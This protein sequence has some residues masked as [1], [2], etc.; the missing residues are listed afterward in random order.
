MTNVPGVFA[1]GDGQHGPRTAVEAIRSGKIA[2][3]SIDAWLLGKPMDPSAGK[4]VHR[5]DVVPLTVLC[6]SVPTDAA[7]PCPNGRSRKRS[8]RAT[9]SESRRA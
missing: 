1:G 6:K 9:T 4:A 5:A 3:A 2:A 7:P 8:V